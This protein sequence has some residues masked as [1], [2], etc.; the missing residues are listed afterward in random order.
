MITLAWADDSLENL[1][2]SLG[3]P[4]PNL[5]VSIRDPQTNKVMGLNEVGEICNRGDNTMLEYHQNPDATSETIDDEQWLH[6]GDLGTMDA[7]GYVRI[8]GR[9]KEMII[10]GGENIYPKEIENSLLEH[11]DTV[12]YTHLTLPTNDLV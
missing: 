12:S 9:V 3:Q 5:D 8:A 2:N 6:T 7:E 4:L 10:R 11:N 1:T